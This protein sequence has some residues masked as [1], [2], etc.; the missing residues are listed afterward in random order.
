MRKF[1]AL[2][3]AFMLMCVA[4]TS[5]GDDKDEEE[6]EAPVVYT[7]TYDA[8]GG[9]GTIANTT[10]KAGEKVTLSDGS[11]FSRDGY[12]FAG[13]SNTPDG[14]NLDVNA[15][16]GKNVTL[17]AVWNKVNVDPTPSAEFTIK[18]DANGGTGTIASTTYKVGEQITLS[19]GTGFTRE[20]YVFK[21]WSNTADGTELDVNAITGNDITLY[22]VW[23]QALLPEPLV[24][25]TLDLDG[26]AFVTAALPTTFQVVTGTVIGA[27]N[28][29]LAIPA[30]DG[31]TF[32]GWATEKGGA[33]IT[34]F[35]AD[36]DATLYAIWEQNSAQNGDFTLIAQVKGI[37]GKEVELYAYIDGYA[38]RTDIDVTKMTLLGFN[39]VTK[40]EAFQIDLSKFTACKF[41]AETGSFTTKLEKEAGDYQVMAVIRYG[42][43]VKMSATVDFT[44]EGGNG[45][46]NNDKPA[47][48]GFFFPKA[49]DPANVEVWYAS[50]TKE[51]DATSYDAAYFFKNGTAIVAKNIIAADGSS[52]T[53]VIDYVMSMP[54]IYSLVEGDYTNGKI[55]V[56]IQIMPAYTTAEVKNGVLSVS[57]PNIMENSSFNKQDNKDIPTPSK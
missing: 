28:E 1:F 17:Y 33:A 18:Y 34:S 57:I 25:I 39:V 12:T 50:T 44:I 45:G 41:D 54:L 42:E 56:G 8:N 14:T 43:Q 23:E 19:D 6:P 53:S 46:G 51:G 40:G 4:F 49:Y 9:T 37:N 16:T 13:W 48:S 38:D 35:T 52:T 27:D 5:C 26:G 31:F 15:L 2:M 36:K 20:G 21:G 32:K 10:Y 24:T 30:K 22:A 3:T 7:I 47:A 11:G 29:N 55:S